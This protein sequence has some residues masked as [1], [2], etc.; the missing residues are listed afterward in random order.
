LLVSDSLA[1]IKTESFELY[2]KFTSSV[3]NLYFFSVLI[4]IISINDFSS[5]INPHLSQTAIIISSVS[6]NI[7]VF[8]N[9]LFCRGKIAVPL[10]SKPSLK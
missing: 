1:F 6:K 8:L 10:S 5:H 4:F 9:F 2:I 7:S 3:N